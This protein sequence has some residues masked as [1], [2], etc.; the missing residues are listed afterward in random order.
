MLQNHDIQEDVLY[1]NDPRIQI[2]V[3]EDVKMV[4]RGIKLPDFQDI[5]GELKSMGMTTATNASRR[6]TLNMTSN[7]NRSKPKVKK[8]RESKRMKYTN[9]HLPELLKGI[10]LPPDM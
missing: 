2:N 9:V 6:A 5:E 8:R 3:D 7:Q 4:F 10:D 1:P